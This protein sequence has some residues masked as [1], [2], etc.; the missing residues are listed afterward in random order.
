MQLQQSTICRGAKTGSR[1]TFSPLRRSSST[2]VTRALPVAEVAQ[3]ATHAE[4]RECM[5]QRYSTQSVTAVAGGWVGGQHGCSLPAATTLQLD[6]AT[7]A[8]LS[9][10]CQLLMNP[11]YTLAAA[12]LHSN[13]HTCDSLSAAESSG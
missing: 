6:T 9:R 8:Q 1:A 11:V 10:A 7:I 3:L 12:E 13:L 2:T 5:D 4:P